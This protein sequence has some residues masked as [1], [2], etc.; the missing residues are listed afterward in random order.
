MFSQQWSDNS[1]IFVFKLRW[2]DTQATWTDLF[3]NATHLGGYHGP[4]NLTFWHTCNTSKG[5]W[6]SLIWSRIFKNLLYNFS[7][8]GH[9]EF[10]VINWHK[11]TKG[12]TLV[13]HFLTGAGQFQW[14]SYV[15]S[16]LTSL[17]VNPIVT[18]YFL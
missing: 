17:H 10:R 4:S 7:S 18:S 9:L 1:W 13:E 3:G 2:A 6:R 5:I 14:P 8:K 16:K 15:T 11:G 12:Y